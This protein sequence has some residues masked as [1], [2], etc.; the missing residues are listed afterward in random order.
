MASVE[1]DGMCNLYAYRIM[2][3]EMAGLIAHFKLVGR[4]FADVIRMKND[5][6]ADVYPT[7][8]HRCW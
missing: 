2:P 3:E 4:Q 7:A 6:D 1:L 5:P 8:E